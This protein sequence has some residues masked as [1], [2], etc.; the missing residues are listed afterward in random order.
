M[1]IR[2]YES[3]RGVNY[4]PFYVALA[5]KGF[6]REGLEIDLTTSS[7]GEE[8]AQALLDGRMDVAWGGPMR[9]MARHDRDPDCPLVCFAQVLACDPFLLIGREARAGFRLADLAGLKLA[10]PFDPATPWCLLQEDLRRVGVAP[11]AVERVG[12]LSQPDA[13]AAVADGA[14]DAALLLQPHAERLLAAG[15]GHVWYAGAIRGPVAFTTFYTTR[16]QVRWKPAAMRGLVRALRH[17]LAECASE[18]PEAIA[19][20]VGPWFPDIERPLLAASV[21]RYQALGVWPESPALPAEAFV[22]LKLALISGGWIARD[23]PYDRAV[24]AQITDDVMREP[25]PAVPA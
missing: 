12:D 16:E 8:T 5:R 18:P 3:F 20:T 15:R 7:S 10:A 11:D 23:V 24:L 14:I 21:A 13:A 17:A 6:E 22:R 1:R 4:T 25:P 9:V 19:D 2:L